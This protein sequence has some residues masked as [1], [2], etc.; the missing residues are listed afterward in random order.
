MSMRILYLTREA[1]PSFR[2]DLL[3]L[4]GQCLPKR[5]VYCDLVAMAAGGV[6]APW[7]A[8]RVFS[9][10]SNSRIL[11]LVLRLILPFK[12]FTLP[13]KETYGAIQVRDRVVGAL[14][15][16]VAAKF[17]RI[18]FFYWM[19]FP[20]P[21]SWLDLGSGVDPSNS[22]AK[23]R[24]FWRLRGHIASWI[25]YKCVLPRATHIFVQ[26]QAMREMLVA[27]GIPETRMTPV[28]MG[29]VLPQNLASIVPSDDSRLIGRKVLVYLGALERVRRPEVMIE[30]MAL[31]V[32]E[33]PKALLVLVG[34]SQIP[35]ERLWLE[36]E[37]ARLG[38]GDSVIITGWLPQSEA[39]RYLCA[40]RVG[41]SPFPRT[42]VLDV[43]S[44][45]KVCEYLAYG[46]PV[47]ANDQRDQAELIARTRGGYC[48]QLSPAAF[49]RA[50]CDL[51]AAPVEAAAM[52][53]RG[54][55]EIALL[56]SYEV[57][58]DDLVTIYEKLLK[59]SA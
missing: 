19:S 29:V 32:R 11:R 1:Y 23:K 15:G 30:A 18:P 39:L 44:P 8:G 37:I 35:G 22:S 17:Y 28:P 53:A 49:A 13:R 36:S 9:S 42:R 34:D 31:V 21:E 16:L 55:Q 3:N 14:I 59:H 33:E 25:L 56:R 24:L 48:V 57:I 47:V 7:G 12:L 54:R 27:R 5:S 6:D 10:K 2:P 58:A 41:L 26:S 46:V 45:T 4:F 51:L 52:G 38:L 43:A 20:F 50:A 40:G